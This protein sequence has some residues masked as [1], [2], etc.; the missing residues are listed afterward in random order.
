MTDDVGEIQRRNREQYAG[1]APAYAASES[2]AGGADLEWFTARARTVAPATALDV[3]CGGGF[4]TR[5][6]LAAGHRVVATDLTPESVAAARAV[7]GTGRVHWV[8]GAAEALPLRAGSVGV[9]GCRIAPH[10]FGDPAHFVDEVVRVLRPGGM[11]LLVDTT[12]PEDEELA[13]WLNQIEAIRDPS[14]VRARPVS[15][16]RA[17]CTGAGLQ[18]DEALT[19]AKRHPLE[20]WLA[21]S[22]CAGPAADEVRRRFATAPAGARDAFRIEPDAY[23][24]RKL[25]LRATRP[26]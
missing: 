21:R 13:A 14:H 24:D 26:A 2:H 6:L 7:T 4:S 5:A 3:A 10:H 23:T 22:G 12:V 25:C 18:V 9:V 16:W 20:P 8:A 15:W 11:L 19:V 1:V 17:I